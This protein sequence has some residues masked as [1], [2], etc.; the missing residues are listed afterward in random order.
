[1]SRD[2]ILRSASESTLYKSQSSDRVYV[3]NVFEENATVREYVGGYTDWLRQGHRLAEVDNPVSTDARRKEARRDA[4][5]NKPRKLS[6]TEARELEKLP[7][8]IESL[9][10]ELY[11][12]QSQI[13]EPNFYAAGQEAVQPVL[14]D[15]TEQQKALSDAT[16]RWAALE[17]KQAQYDTSRK[18]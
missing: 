12:L 3:A 7:S 9:E 18:G 17:D 4:E 15:L 10:T 6:Y 1:M 8:L 13:A 11:R 14:R 2:L 5:R 16:D